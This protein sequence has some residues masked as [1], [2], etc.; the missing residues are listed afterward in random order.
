[1]RFV[2]KNGDRKWHRF[3]FYRQERKSQESRTVV[4]DVATL[5]SDLAAFQTRLTT[6]LENV[7]WSLGECLC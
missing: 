1:M 6:K 7:F 4:A 3:G 5:L 2:L